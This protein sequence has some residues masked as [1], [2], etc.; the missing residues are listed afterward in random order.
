MAKKTIKL[1]SIEAFYI[2]HNPDKTPEQLALEIK[3]PADLIRKHLKKIK[4]KE[5]PQVT[6]DGIPI[7]KAGDFFVRNKRYGVTVMTKQAAEISDE[8]RRSNAIK[9]NQSGFIRPAKR[10]DA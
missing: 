1:T 9:Q 5:T 7:P 10:E 8:H 3:K 4:P 2:E 6:E